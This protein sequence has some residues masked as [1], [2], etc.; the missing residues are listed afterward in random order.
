MND[1]WLSRKRACGFDVGDIVEYNR[2]QS[3]APSFLGI[4]LGLEIVESNLYEKGY[5]EATICWFNTFINSKKKSQTFE[6]TRCLRK[7]C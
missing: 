2:I 7:V 5:V 6:D 3:E 1:Y 4:V